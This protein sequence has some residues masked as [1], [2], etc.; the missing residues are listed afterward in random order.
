MQ[1]KPIYLIVIFLISASCNTSQ[2]QE[3]NAEN[4]K[5]KMELACACAVPDR[6]NLTADA[7]QPATHPKADSIKKMGAVLILRS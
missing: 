3:S 4:D 6:L 5:K 2:K 7:E 1:I